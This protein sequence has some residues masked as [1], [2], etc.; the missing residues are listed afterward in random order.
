MTNVIVSAFY[1]TIIIPILFIDY[2]KRK[3]TA[4]ALQKNVKVIFTK[5]PDKSGSYKIYFLI[6]VT[7]FHPFAAWPLSGAWSFPSLHC[8]H[9]KR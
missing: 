9:P 6:Q 3:Q 5:K 1:F 8:C 4:I 2:F 7:S